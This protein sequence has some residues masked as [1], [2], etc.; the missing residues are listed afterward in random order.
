[1]NTL[2]RLMWRCTK[3]KYQSEAVD[4]CREFGA[5]IAGADSRRRGAASAGPLAGSCSGP[6][7]TSRGT[8]PERYW[9][10]HRQRSEANRSN[11]ISKRRRRRRGYRRSR[12]RRGSTCRRGAGGG[13]LPFWESWSSVN[14]TRAEMRI[15]KQENETQLPARVRQVNPKIG[16][17]HLERLAVVY[18]RQSTL[19]QT[20][21]N[22]ESTRMQY[23]LVDRAIQLGWA[24]ERVMVIDEDLGRSGA[25]AEGRPGFQRLVAEVG[26]DHVGLVLGVE[27]SR[28]AR[29]CRDWHQL[30][31]ACAIFGT[32]I[33][34]L[35]GIYDPTHYNDRLLLGLKG[36]MSEAELH[37][38]KQR[39]LQGALAKARRGE[40]GLRLPMGYFRRP[41]GEVTKD[42]DEQARAV[43]QMVLDQFEARGTVHGVLRY[44]VRNSIRM[45]KRVAGGPRKGELEWVAPNRPTIQEV[46]HHP[47][48]AGAYVY[49][50]RP[51]DPRRRKPGR[52]GTGRV[53]LRD[54]GWEVLLRDRLPA[55][56]TW[57]QY[58]ANRKQL[59]S[60]RSAA[61]GV[62]RRG[63][64]LLSGLLVCGRCGYR[65]TVDY[66][67][68]RV[69]Y[70][71]HRMHTQRAASHCCSMVGAPLEEHVVGLV[72]QALQP[73]ALEVS[74]SVA[75]DL[76]A[77]RARLDQ[78]WQHRLE[79]VRYE[80]DRAMRQ[81]NAVE[82]E[83]R[84]VA[85]TVEHAFEDALAAQK[86]LEEEHARFLADQPSML[87]ED[88]LATIRS[89]AAD[90][91]ALWEATTTTT[92]DRQTIIRQIVDKIVVT[93]EGNTERV[94]VV[95]HWAGGHETTSTLIR[96]V[97][98][99]EQLS[100]NPRL[101]E[102]I[103]E[104][105]RSDLP[106][107]AIAERLNEEGFRG[108]IGRPLTGATVRS[109]A[110]RCGLA[111]GRAPR[112]NPI[113]SSTEWR[114]P[115]LA[116]ALD[117]PAIT[118]YGWLQRGWVRA[119]R[120]DAPGRPW[121]ILAD[122]RELARLRA[123]RAASSPHARATKVACA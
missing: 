2:A 86:A 9:R 61:L 96:P 32:L 26:L 119:C 42:P 108:P 114:L 105:H 116:R 28:L 25:S 52:P 77:E 21:R 23:G 60:N 87:S 89:L 58:E 49:G 47:I 110:S 76:E 117:M 80:V 70:D 45:P 19:Q 63:A 120:A 14:E 40:L 112:T 37:V 27:M 95:V 97:A 78:A 5:E 57:E 50:R 66:N 12:S 13:S 102:R 44:L 121:I 101:V 103:E 92:A 104:L 106:S 113:C 68:G 46:L 59:A 20:V 41:S 3:S 69:R 16:S 64:A 38:L 109:L 11:R 111:L 67:N 91:P 29:S 15:T 22:Q 122:A 85:R 93:I 54:G 99:W 107:H 36:T 1:M 74:L 75:A 35:D 18:V 30:L 31:E 71:C 83:N 53:V 62:P 34:D 123:L 65:M 10:G 8:G 51:T 94:S 55:Y 98:R 24:R 81:Y 90:I 115:A 82:P 88:E 48:Y 6:I 118:L 84:L 72:L 33:G 7:A 4:K 56:I 43:I 39:M 100:S 17:R 79:R 73:A